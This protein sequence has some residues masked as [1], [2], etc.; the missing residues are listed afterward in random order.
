[1]IY[2]FG[3]LAV[4]LILLRISDAADPPINRPTRQQPPWNRKRS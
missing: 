1:M 4:L 3:G 2:I